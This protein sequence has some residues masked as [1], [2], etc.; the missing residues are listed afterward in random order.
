[1]RDVDHL[2]LKSI[3]EDHE[4]IVKGKFGEFGAY[5]FKNAY[6]PGSGADPIYI[7]AKAKK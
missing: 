6:A 2:T 3:N 1:M 4:L 7:F 5:I